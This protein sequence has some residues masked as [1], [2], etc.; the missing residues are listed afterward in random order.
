MAQNFAQNTLVKSTRET[1]SVFCQVDGGQRTIMWGTN[2]ALQPDGTTVRSNLKTGRGT[3]ACT[4]LEKRW[5]NAAVDS[6]LHYLVNDLEVEDFFRATFSAATITTVA[7]ATWA[8][9]GT[10]LDGS[11][12]PIL[13][14]GATELTALAGCEGA[15]LVTTD[16]LASGADPANLRARA[17]KAIAAD[18]S[19]LDFEP[20]Y[21]TGGVGLVGEPL[22][23]EGPLA[24]TVDC[25]EFLRDGPVANARSINIEHQFV[26]IN[27]A[28]SF[29]LGRGLKA[30][31]WALGVTGAGNTTHNISYLGADYDEYTTTTQG[32]GAE[33][34]NPGAS[35]CNMTGGRIAH[36]WIDA[37]SDLAPEG[38]L[39]SFDISG[40]GTANGIDGTAGL[41]SRAGVTLGEHVFTGSMNFL[42]EHDITLLVTNRARSGGNVPIDLKSVDQAGNYYW[43]RLPQVILKPGGPTPEASGDNA[44]DF[45]FEASEKWSEG[46]AGLVGLRTCIVQ[47]FPIA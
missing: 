40:D 33:I 9:A 11:T 23:D 47:R 29:Y 3:V 44:A 5:C 38:M 42:N 18:G 28:A 26:D 41:L 27:S 25:G 7:A 12:G 35:Y 30:A 20:Q 1:E 32:A 16:P 6:E 13:T 39:T 17:I 21:V 10:Q 15:M 46:E 19:Q 37:V 2:V 22:V 36:L 24:V 4:A 14:V 34:D 45:S 43:H 31:T 8:N